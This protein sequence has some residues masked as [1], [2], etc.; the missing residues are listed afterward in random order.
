M[1]SNVVMKSPDRNL[2]GITIR[3]NTKEQFLSVSDLQKAYETA[4]WQHGWS[5]RKVADILNTEM[6][7]E[8]VFSLLQEKSLI[9]ADR[10]GFM[11]MVNK[12]GLTK[13]LK[14]LGLYKTTG[15]GI[16]KTVMADPYIWVLL[17]M[18]L[19]PL[20]WAKTIIFITDTLI[21]DRIEA[22][23][24]YMPMNTAIKSLINNPDYAKYAKEINERVFG[25]HIT[26]A[27]QLASSKQLKKIAAI[28]RFVINAI[29]MGLIKSDDDILNVI[30]NYK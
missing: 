30:K 17:A 21:F 20:L 25:R 10:L 2:F 4:R 8:R 5:D 15:R 14:G 3:Q 24:E 18:E 12:E 29:Q 28:E 1:Q 7:R 26:G 6:T 16:N 11:E 22:G 9:K 13:V 23:T 19:N 27:R